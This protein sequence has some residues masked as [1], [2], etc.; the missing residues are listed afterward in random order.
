MIISQ[1]YKNKIRLEN[2]RAVQRLLARTINLLNDDQI[3]ESKA[4]AVGYLSN[5][6][7]KSMEIVELEQRIAEL[8]QLHEKGA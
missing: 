1:I 2:P 4:R 7:L 8:E 5:I 3:D 6:L